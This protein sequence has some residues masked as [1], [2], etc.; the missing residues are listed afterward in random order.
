MKSRFK[1][2]NLIKDTILND[3]KDLIGVYTF[4]NG[5]LHKAISIS[6]RND[7]YPPKGTV[8]K[9]LEVVIFPGVSVNV[10]NFLGSKSWALTSDISL[11]QWNK[12][13]DTYEILERIHPGLQNLGKLTI[14]PLVQGND[15]ILESRRLSLTQ[16]IL[17]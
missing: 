4:Q 12:N 2:G 3:A 1:I 6:N 7:Q 14:N 5:V 15:I 16:S 9:G 11:I 17:I 8:I 10:T 13:N